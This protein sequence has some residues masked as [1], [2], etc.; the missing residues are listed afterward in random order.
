METDG[1]NATGGNELS[2]PIPILRTKFSTLEKTECSFCQA[3]MPNNYY[4]TVECDNGQ[5]N[6]DGKRVCGY[7]FCFLCRERWNISQEKLNICINCFKS[8]EV[9]T[10]DP[11]KDAEAANNVEATSVGISEATIKNMKVKDLKGG[12]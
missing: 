5:R 9:A 10:T 1:C 8:K 2:D 6:L 12:A 4:C 11:E 3:S 7:A